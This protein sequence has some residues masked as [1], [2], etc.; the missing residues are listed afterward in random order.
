MF[1]RRLVLIGLLMS[2]PFLPLGA[3]LGWVTLVKGADARTQAES[4]LVRQSWE[5][6]VRG[7][8]L[9]RNGRV[10]AQDRPSYDLAISYEVISGEWARRSAE[11]FARRVHRDVWPALDADERAAWVRT[12]QPA[13]EQRVEQ[14]WGLIAQGA[15]VS[16]DDIEA[17]RRTVVE[18][19]E[20]MQAAVTAR[21][22][23][24]E[25]ENLRRAGIRIGQAEEARIRR[26]ADSPIAERTQAHPIVSGVADDIGFRFMRLAERDAPV[27]AAGEAGEA[28]L[29]ERQPLLP[30][31][32]VIDATERV[33]PYD[34]MR[35]EIDRTTLPA[36]LRGD[37]MM[38]V[39]VEEIAGLMLGS[40]RRR[41]FQEDVERRRRRIEEDAALRERALTQRGVDTGAYFL[42][43][44]RVGHTGIEAAMEDALR[45]FRGLRRE[46]LQTRA[47]EHRAAIPGDDVRL[48]IDIQLQARVRAILDPEVGLTRVQP[49]HQNSNLPA[50]TELDAA[51]VVLDIPTG[52]I[53]AMVSM[54]EAPRDGDWSRRG[55]QGEALERYLAVHTPFVNRAI[56]KPYQPGSIV[57]ALILC[58]ATKAGL[59]SPGE[60][61]RATGHYFPNRPNMFRS[62]IYKQYGITH[63]DQLGR[64][65][66]DSDALM[67]SSNVFFFTLG[68][69]LGPRGVAEVY[70]SFGIGEGFGLGLGGE[71]PGS[72]GG[73]TNRVV[74]GSDLERHDA[75]FLGIGQGPITWTPLHAADSYATIARGGYRIV[76]RLIAEQ[77]VA[78][79]V[80]DL[81]IPSSAIRNTL[82]GLR[83]AANDWDFG[84]GM[85]ININGTNDRIF[86]A[87]GVTVWGKT[88]TADASPV[89]WKPGGPESDEPAVVVRQGDHSWYVVLVGDEGEAPRYA[90]A[91]VVDFGG[92]GGRVSGPITNQIIHALIQEGYLGG[93]AGPGRRA[94]AAGSAGGRR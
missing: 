8:I 64:D 90:I 38:Q 70:R 11:R 48:T 20:R 52:E 69:R 40:V 79:Q 23:E 80:I 87:P 62:W 93:R 58:G 56:G 3:R 15:G 75:I 2:L 41:V 42:N 24:T 5:P 54:P 45:G 36:P 63:A 39:E 86:N 31:L 94:D 73:L 46:N 43:G 16:R 25:R 85:R 30:G 60:R 4:R 21:R 19:V 65:P 26:I 17:S 68:D 27:F 82:D 7:R 66:D 61:I 89:V 81:G 59:Y 83:R 76:P 29:D 57:K 71:W 6:T 78:P 92:S 1:H 9:D 67:V 37:G 32:R 55:L 88:G 84:T 53:L 12:Y 50:G 33:Y 10:L 28:A 22:I 74:D 72:I 35:V 14:M 34:R 77:G 18:R 47:V 49:W 13:Y 51:A 44:D 91:V